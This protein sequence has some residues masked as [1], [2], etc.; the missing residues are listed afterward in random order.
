M[1]G[2]TSVNPYP[3]G[4]TPLHAASGS[5]AAASAAAT[6]PAAPGKTTYATGF[7]ITSGGATA[8]ALV[9]ATL[10]GVLGGTLTYVYGTVAGVAA[11]NAPLIVRFPEAVPASAANTAITLTLPTLGAGN[12]Q[13]AVV[14]HGY[15]L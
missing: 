9:L 1:G 13:A 4:A 8:A 10:A 7:E 3:E 15:Q 12:L 2:F 11:A 14:L 6:L 5:V